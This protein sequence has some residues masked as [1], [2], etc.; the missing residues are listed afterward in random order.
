MSGMRPIHDAHV[1]QPGLAVVEVAAADDA[2]AFAIQDLLAATTPTQST[3][4]TVR[5]VIRRTWC[6]CRTQSV[7]TACPPAERLPNRC[8][9]SSPRR[10][11]RA[12]S[13][14]TT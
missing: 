7:R 11:V 1:H 6:P 3:R 4:P 10:S 9:R 12:H 5:S 8:R 2:T 13:Y 14:Q